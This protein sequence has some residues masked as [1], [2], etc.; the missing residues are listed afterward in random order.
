M[1][2]KLVL[3]ILPLAARP[4]LRSLG[5]DGKPGGEGAA[6]DLEGPR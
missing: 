3:A 5:A 6:A 2:P 4:T 1:F